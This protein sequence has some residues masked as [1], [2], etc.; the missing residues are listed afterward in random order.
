VRPLG[1]WTQLVAAHREHGVHID[2]K[3]ATTGWRGETMDYG[4][5]LDVLFQ[6]VQ[7]ARNVSAETSA[8]SG[9]E[10]SRIPE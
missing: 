7:R 9:T 8:R 5:G 10:D 4:I 2:W 1:C 6:R 3:T